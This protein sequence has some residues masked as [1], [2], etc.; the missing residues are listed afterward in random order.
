M[1]FHPITARCP[2]TSPL[3]SAKYND[4]TRFVKDENG[5]ERYIGK[6]ERAA[7]AKQRKVDEARRLIGQDERDRA[8][9]A[10]PNSPGSPHSSGAYGSPGAYG[11]QP[12]AYPPAGANPY[13]QQHQQ[14]R[15]YVDQ[16]QVSMNMRS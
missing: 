7:L 15:I 6:N 16:S 3:H 14:Q 1:R 8:A 9:Y 2:H 12:G 11:P 10:S 13:E 5:N 4:T